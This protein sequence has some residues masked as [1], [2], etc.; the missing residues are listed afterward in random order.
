MIIDREE[1]INRISKI[2]EVAGLQYLCRSNNL[3]RYVTTIEV[4]LA[5]IDEETVEKAALSIGLGVQTINRGLK[6]LYSNVLLNG[7][8]ETWHRYFLLQ[9][10]IKKCNKCN[11]YKEITDFYKV[12][13]TGKDGLHHICKGCKSENNK[14]YYSEH[15]DYWIAYEKLHWPDYVRRN[16]E[17]RA[18]LKQ[19]IPLWANLDKIKIIYNDRP[20]GYHIDHYYPLYGENVCGLHVENNL[21]CITAEENMAKGNMMPENFYYLNEKD[22]KNF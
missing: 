4:V 1:L 17:R 12:T 20:D 5:I 7:G 19:A 6:K 18:R 8:H 13:Y 9:C 22:G 15:V 11:L 14:D 21:K 3:K 2:P 10:D 16:A